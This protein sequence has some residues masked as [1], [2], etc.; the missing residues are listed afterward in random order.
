MKILAFVPARGGS[1]GI[2]KKN[3]ILLNKKPLIKYTLETIDSLGNLVH[4]F[5]ST[6]SKEILKYCR[7]QGFKTSYLRPKLLSSNKSNV[8]DALLHGINWIKKNQKIDFD[9]ILLLQPTSPLRKTIE[10]KKAIKLFNDKKLK[11]LASVVRM[12]ES[13]FECIEKKNKKWEYL[14]KPAKDIYRRQQFSKNF[15]FIDGTFYLA[16]VDFIKKNKT[17]FNNKM[18]TPF[19]LDRDWPIDIDEKNDLLVAETF[20]KKQ[21]KSSK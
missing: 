11:S 19:I 12:R 9:T 7:S 13:P 6:D 21:A 17:F 4:P 8:V 5:I 2:K 3:L 14:K 18:T 10:I 1:Q 20:I 16:K 15:Y